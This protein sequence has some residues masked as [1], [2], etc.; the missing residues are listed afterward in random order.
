MAD[1][2]IHHAGTHVPLRRLG[3]DPFERARELPFDAEGHG[4][5]QVFVEQL[6]MAEDHAFEIIGLDPPEELLEPEYLL[7]GP[8]SRFGPR[9]HDLREDQQH[10]P[11][12]NGGDDEWN[13]CQQE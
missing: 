6:G 10:D 13:R 3:V 7:E 12:H 1:V 8:R 2:E 5:R 9:R 11:R 4:V